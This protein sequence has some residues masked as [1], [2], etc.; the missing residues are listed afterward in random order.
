MATAITNSVQPSAVSSAVPSDLRTASPIRVVTNAGSEAC[1][2]LQDLGFAVRVLGA[3]ALKAPSAA[4][5]DADIVIV[6]SSLMG[7]WSPLDG[8]EI[9][10]PVVLIVVDESIDVVHHAGRC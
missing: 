2:R 8:H 1:E 3:A 5:I 7:T 10:A 9:N 4:D 6:D